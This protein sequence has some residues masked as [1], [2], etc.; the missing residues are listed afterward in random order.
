MKLLI[1]RAERGSQ[2]VHYHF[3]T[4]TSLSDELLFLVR[5]ENPESGG[6]EDC[7]HAAKGGEKN[8]EQEI[9]PGRAGSVWGP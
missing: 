2:S 7:F 5:A 6:R 1:T 4:Q 3:L 9:L 8:S